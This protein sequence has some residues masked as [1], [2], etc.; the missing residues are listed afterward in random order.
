MCLRLSLPSNDPAARRSQRGVYA[1]EWAIIFPVFFGLLYAIISYG[2]SFL[3]R[4]SM[5]H[6]V[7]EGARA[8]LRYPVG[9]STPN[10]NDRKAAA[11]TAIQRNLQWLPAA[12]QPNAGNVKF[13]V[14]RV[15]A[16]ENASCTQETALSPNLSCD[17]S[18]PCMV[19]VSYAIAN[20]KDNAIAPSIPGL[21]VV[22]PASLQAKASLLVDR[23][24]L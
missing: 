15:S 22:L 19:L 18:T 16:L 2:L 1:V 4:E 20:Y 23:K 12:I 17:V 7:E 10:W 13:T 11:M 14:C 8:A 21:G 3:V 9:I 24:M 5:Q 6:A